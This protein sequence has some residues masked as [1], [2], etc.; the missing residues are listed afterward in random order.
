MSQDSNLISYINA[1]WDLLVRRAIY[2]ASFIIAIIMAKLVVDIF[3]LPLPNSVLWACGAIAL[4]CYVVSECVLYA[5]H[6]QGPPI[7]GAKAQP[8]QDTPA[9]AIA[10]QNP[11]SN[12]VNLKDFR[13]TPPQPKA[14]PN[15]VW[16]HYYLTNSILARF[17]VEASGT[18]WT[19]PG[20]APDAII[21]EIKRQ[22]VAE[23]QAKGYANVTADQLIMRSL[24][25]L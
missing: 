13:A 5:L 12:V 17:S 10:D 8:S 11:E 16:Y 24:T 1:E 4:C 7:R 20:Q 14:P 25:R 6:L 2:F 3:G 23:S 9:Q 18:V 22:T 15:A 19:L 21:E